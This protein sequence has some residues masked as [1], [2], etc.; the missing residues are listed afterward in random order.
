MTSTQS[1]PPL[2]D[3]PRLLDAELSR[4]SRFLHV[5]LLLGSLTMTIVVAALWLSE[6]A[7]PARTQ[8]AFGLMSLIGLS[9]ASFALW[10]L[11]ARRTLLGRDRIV[12][13]RM[14]VAFTTAFIAGAL[15]LGYVNGGTAPYS[16]A[17]MG[18]ALLAAAVSLLVRAHRRV[19]SLTSRREALER[20]LGRGHR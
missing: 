10:V 18:L 1:S 12:A 14:A 17:A 19:A 7:L 13:G 3:L 9:W 20:D 16:A 15:A 2:L 8:A 11:T 4:P 6:P 5:A